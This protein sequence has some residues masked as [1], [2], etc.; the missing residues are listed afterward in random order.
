MKG[1]CETLWEMVTTSPS[2]IP[3]FKRWIFR[4]LSFI[5][6]SFT[7]SDDVVSDNSIVMDD[8]RGY[9]IDIYFEIA[10]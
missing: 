3:N 1:P 9:F 2:W 5:S 6:T 7:F 8:K 4:D 10:T